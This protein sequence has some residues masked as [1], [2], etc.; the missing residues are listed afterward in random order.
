MIEDC[1]HAL[2]ATLSRPAGRHAGRRRALQLSD[3][4]AAEHLRRRHG[5]VTRSRSRRSRLRRLP[6]PSR[7]DDRQT[8]KKRFWHG[9]VQRIATRPSMFTWTLFPLMCA[10]YAGSTGISTCYFWEQIRPLDPLP[11]DY[12]ERFSNVQAALGSRPSPFS[13]VDTRHPG[14]CRADERAPGGRAGRACAGCAGRSDPRVLSVLRLRAGARRRRPRVPEARHRPRDAARRRLH[15]A[16]DLRRVAVRPHARRAR[17]PP[18]DPDPGLRVADRRRSSSSSRHVV[19][20]RRAETERG[21]R[22]LHQS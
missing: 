2:G 18:R 9:R 16:A 3:A 7:P 15:R 19:P 12:R 17:R 5:V 4:Q 13:T 21:P 20:R 6:Q 14:A 10:C 22:R 1:A 8:S 11:P